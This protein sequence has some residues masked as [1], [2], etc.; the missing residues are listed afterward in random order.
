MVGQGGWQGGTLRNRNNPYLL[1][2]GDYTTVYH[3]IMNWTLKIYILYSILIIYQWKQQKRNLFLCQA[4]YRLVNNPRW[5]STEYEK[6]LLVGFI[7]RRNCLP[8]QMS[9]LWESLKRSLQRGGSG[10]NNLLRK[11]KW[12]AQLLYQQI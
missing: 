2:S 1:L 9:V 10:V 3:S 8:A 7:G 11:H 5:G 6:L 12:K 4:D